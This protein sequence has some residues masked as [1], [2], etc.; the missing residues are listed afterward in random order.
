MSPRA[1]G[2]VA[3]PAGTFGLILAAA[4]GFCALARAEPPAPAAAEAD[5]HFRQGVALFKEQSYAA[6]LVEF[7]KA[8]SLVPDYHVLY[9]VGMAEL[10]LKDDAGAF[11]AF[12]RYL[13][14]ATAISDKRRAEV[15]ANLDRLKLRVG[16]L[17]VSV[18][19][20]G[21]DVAIDDVSVGKAPIA[22]PVVVGIGRR[23]VV[24]TLPDGQQASRVVDVAAQ[25]S[26]PVDLVFAQDTAAPQTASSP[27]PSTAPAL[28]TSQVGPLPEAP[29][30]E[31]RP[32]YLW[33]GIAVTGALAAGGVATGLLALKAKSDADSDAGQLGIAPSTLQGANDQKHTLAAASDALFAATAVAAGVTL[34]FAL[35][36]PG[37]ATSA[38]TGGAWAVGLSP[39]RAVI[40]GTF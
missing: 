2:F 5:M 31:H 17:R 28:A 25:D 30:P 14:E 3:S 6:A 35:R 40:Q 16:T 37:P 15:Q 8:Y 1:T 13:R 18:S 7:R 32:D 33:V 38:A 9:D 23:R 10:E 20:E 22:Q 26:V 39:M 24:A 11:T 21:A 29:P 27:Q 4:M 19:R 36:H 34:Y 12:D